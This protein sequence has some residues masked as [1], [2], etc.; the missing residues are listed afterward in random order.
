MKEFVICGRKLSFPDGFAFYGEI[1][2]Q[3]DLE[4]RKAD[5][6]LLKAYDRWGDI[7]TVVKYMDGWFLDYY[8]KTFM[9]CKGIALSY[10][11]YDYGEAYLQGLTNYER[12]QIIKPYLDAS[13]S[14]RG[15]L[16]EINNYQ[17]SEEQR[18]EYRKNSRTRL[19][20]GGFGV[21]GAAKGMAIA[22]AVN[23]GTG[24]AHG[25]FN[26]VGNLFTSISA[27]S[28]R[29]ELYSHAL[30]LLRS[31]VRE[32]LLNLLPFVAKVVKLNIKIDSQKEA[33]ILENIT[34]GS[35]NGYDLNQ[36]FA[37][38]FIAYPFDEKLYIAYLMTY[39]EELNNIKSMSP[40]FGV[41]LTD[42]I[43]N[44]LDVNGY[45][46]KDLETANYVREQENNF[47]KYF[48]IA[49]G[50]QIAN[51]IFTKDFIY[52]QGN[53]TLLNLLI[54]RYNDDN[55]MNLNNADVH[56]YKKHMSEFYSNMTDVYYINDQERK[57]V[58]RYCEGEKYYRI[59]LY[60]LLWEIYIKDIVKLNNSSVKY[61]I[62]VGTSQ[63]SIEDERF[64]Q[65]LYSK[66]KQETDYL[67]AYYEQFKEN[68][69]YIIASSYGIETSV[70]SNGE[71]NRYSI[72][73]LGVKDISYEKNFI[74]SSLK[75]NSEECAE[76]THIG[77]DM[78]LIVKF[79]SGLKMRELNLCEMQVTLMDIKKTDPNNWWF[80]A[81]N[82][83]YDTN[84]TVVVV[85]YSKAKFWY[86][87][88]VDAG[89]PG[90][91]YDKAVERLSCPEII[92]AK[93]ITEEDALMQYSEVI[94]LM[95]Q[96]T[97]EDTTSSENTI[98]QKNSTDNQAVNPE[99]KNQAENSQ[100]GE[101]NPATPSD[102]SESEA[103]S[104]A[105]GCLIWIVIGYLI[106]RFFM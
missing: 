45:K 20:G 86:K 51:Q 59:V 101:Q 34:N 19:V 31:G 24:L 14:I 32:S 48:D 75:I 106:Y 6:D 91:K 99:P 67:F 54:R 100:N 52:K 21:G 40:Y 25:A 62:H 88:I 7:E 74:G 36:P 64:P 66:Y 37:D 50:V 1:R 9:S 103:G 42:F 105:L 18:R 98:N 11:I 79:L 80:L 8:S 94:E 68:K 60:L 27:S 5:N 15:E 12:D 87:K 35:L 63:L 2:K 70:T 69:E 89:I 77:D 58:L 97:L 26:M 102:K 39:P 55:V 57:I 72:T 47:I 61:C 76:F 56:N 29:S 23:L 95:Q 85:D 53:I 93:D 81:A 46:F 82:Y 4:A 41:D 33:T 104:T 90:P 28:S 17:N 38:A 3:I 96:H 78:N 71:T 49:A 84:N 44:A 43:N 92:N 83:H 16:S 73:W 30:P 22:G 65:L 10:G 13:S